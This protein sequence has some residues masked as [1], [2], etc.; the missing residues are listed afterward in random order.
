MNEVLNVNLKNIWVGL[1]KR[2]IF[3]PGLL[4]SRPVRKQFN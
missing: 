3:K 2:V 4:L 1:E